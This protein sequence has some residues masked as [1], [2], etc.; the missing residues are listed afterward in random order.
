VR[1]RAAEH[2]GEERHAVPG[3]DLGDAAQNVLASL[4]HVV[5]GADAHGGDIA[6]RAHHMFERGDKLGRKSAMGDENH[7]DHA[8]SF[9]GLAAASP[10]SAAVRAEFSRSRWLTPT[11]R[12]CWRSQTARRSAT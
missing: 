7:S 9:S 6:L 12:P 8:M 4:L 10:F 3:I 1:G 11:E 2:V 5:L